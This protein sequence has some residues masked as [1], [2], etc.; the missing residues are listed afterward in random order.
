MVSVSRGTNYNITGKKKGCFHFAVIGDIH[1]GHHKTTSTEMIS[2]LYATFPDTSETAALDLL[3]LNGDVF[4]TLLHRNDLYSG[5]IDTW[6]FN[7]LT[8]CSKHKIKL[9]ALEGTP[10]HDRK[11]CQAFVDAIERH[12][13]VIDFAYITDVYVETLADNQVSLLYVPDEWDTDLHNCYTEAVKKITEAGLQK[14]DLA[15]MHGAFDFQYPAHVPVET[16]DSQLWQPLVNYGIFINHVHQFNEHGVITAPGSFD[17]L[18]HGDENAKGHVRGTIKKDGLFKTFVQNTRAKIYMDVDC[19][20]LSVEEALEKVE[21]AVRELKTPGS[22][23]RL[24]YR[25]TDNISK[26]KDYFRM[27]YPRF[28]WDD[29]IIDPEGKK[30]MKGLLPTR[31]DLY[32]PT[33]LTAGL[34]PGIIER[35][36][37][38][39]NTPDAIV[40]HAMKLL[41]EHL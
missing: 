29:K 17:R 33:S 4:D 14:V 2:K 20:G 36:M 18:C 11:Q 9:R 3:V 24:L 19:C 25:R 26:A 15:F 12:S 23:I 41:L 37:V 7:L 16:Y 30:D 22:F 40:R 34:L 21:N 27:A 39:L 28:Y 31:D 10:S 35:R 13:I 6:I 38:A 1:I 5:T 32:V 8:L